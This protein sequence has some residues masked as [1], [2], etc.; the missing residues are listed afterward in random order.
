M[1]VAN[2][3]ED[4]FL[5]T[6]CRPRIKSKGKIDKQGNIKVLDSHSKSLSFDL[7]REQCAIGK[8]SKQ[9]Y[10][11]YSEVKYKIRHKL[12]IGDSSLKELA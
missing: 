6:F 2:P 3:L 9:R 10:R 8:K 5:P 4:A 1:K 12:G 7:V 11:G